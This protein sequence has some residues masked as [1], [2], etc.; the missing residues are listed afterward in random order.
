MNGILDDPSELGQQLSFVAGAGSGSTTPIDPD[1]TLPYA[2]EISA[3]LEHQLTTDLGARV[4]YVY[5]RMRNSWDI[6]LDYDQVDALNRNT[7]ITTPTCDGCPGQ[8]GAQRHRPAAPPRPVF[9]L[10]PETTCHEVTRI[11][12]G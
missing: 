1:W 8:I 7:P 4:S 3:S 10:L 5:K 6:V 2:D 11:F 9:G 12:A